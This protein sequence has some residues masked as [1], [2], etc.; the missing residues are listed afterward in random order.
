MG[1]DVP[2][3]R[4]LEV[5]SDQS[6]S[7]FNSGIVN[8]EAQRSYIAI[9]LIL[10]GAVLCARHRNLAWLL[11]PFAFLLW[12]IIHID[13]N[14]DTISFIVAPF[15]GRYYRIAGALAI[16]SIVLITLCISKLTH[17]MLQV[18]PGYATFFQSRY[19]GPLVLSLFLALSYGVV[20]NLFQYES[21]YGRTAELTSMAIT[22]ERD[23]WLVSEEE[24]VM[25]QDFA[26]SAPANTIVLGDP[27]FGT[28]YL[29]G[30]FGVPVVFPHTTGR[31]S[32][33]ARWLAVNFRDI[34]TNPRVCQVIDD[35]QANYYYHDTVTHGRSPFFL[36]V[37][38]EDLIDRGILEPV[39]SG[40][41]AMIF[42]ITG[43]DLLR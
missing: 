41:S 27:R 42:R 31:W 9:A 26:A 16:I 30:L 7:S 20:N 35:L 11:I 2:W 3:E 39:T 4:I 24:L 40:G 37:D 43:C 8:F 32:V 36:D 34:G 28:A 10:T 25:Q 15:Y 33:D 19:T 23:W 18:W 14:P 21:R 29:Y 22:R 5:L 17:W 12:A 13:N 1:P 38:F 6:L